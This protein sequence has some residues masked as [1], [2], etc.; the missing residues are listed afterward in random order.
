ME[1][2]DPKS[3]V[4]HTE[5]PPR[6][7]T[8]PWH[9]CWLTNWPCWNNESR[10]QT[11]GIQV[12]LKAETPN[13]VPLTLKTY[14]GS[15]WVASTYSSLLP[16]LL[17]SHNG[18]IISWPPSPPQ[19]SHQLHLDD[20]FFFLF[21]IRLLLHGWTHG[22]CATRRRLCRCSFCCHNISK[23]TENWQR[24]LSAP[25]I[26]FSFCQPSMQDFLRGIN[27]IQQTHENPRGC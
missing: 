22:P 27:Y 21:N 24:G 23:E 15:L 18:V 7:H 20:I 10:L 9:N 25:A 19:L 17:A 26:F 1:L 2:W 16:L 8:E 3:L 13:E 4:S 14:W 12:M 11:E 6:L 5:D